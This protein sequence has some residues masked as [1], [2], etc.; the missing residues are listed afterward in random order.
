MTHDSEHL[1]RKER[2]SKARYYFHECK[3]RGVT[4]TFRQLNRFDSGYSYSHAT[5]SFT[6]FLKQTYTSYLI[7]NEKQDDIVEVD[8]MENIYYI[9][10]PFITIFNN[11]ESSNRFTSKYITVPFFKAND[12]K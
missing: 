7:I 11:N 5:L 2:L 3:K 6:S 9:K 12:K 8:I 10:N 1:F 4:F